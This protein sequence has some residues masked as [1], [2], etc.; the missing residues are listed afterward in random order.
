MGYLTTFT[1]YNDGASDIRKNPQ[2][3]GEKIYEH[4]GARKPLEFGVGSSA[5]LVKVQQT[6]HADDHTIYVNMGNCLTEVN[7]YTPEFKELIRKDPEFANEL[8][9]FVE[10]ELREL[11]SL[12]L[13]E[14]PFEKTSYK[15][16]MAL[17]RDVRTSPE[18]LDLLANHGSWEICENVAKHPNV[19][20]ITLHMLSSNP[21]SSVLQGVARNPNILPMTQRVLSTNPREYVR[22][23]L[24][25]NVKVLAEILKELREDDSLL[26]RA[27]AKQTL[28]LKVES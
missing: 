26:V 23:S 24:A 25:G 13:H 6:R 10:R 17:S 20:G 4:V 15:E 3:F 19:G 22:E 14:K 7:P 18:K 21:N 11:K 27:K 2:V 28:F 8:I 5:N 12:Q 1:V 9:S 16:K